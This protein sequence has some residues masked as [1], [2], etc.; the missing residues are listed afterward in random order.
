MKHHEM[1]PVAVCLVY[2]HPATRWVPLEGPLVLPQEE[3][4][5]PAALV[6]LFC[7]ELIERST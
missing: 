5:R 1:L 2:G 3:G 7:N 6:C 4:D